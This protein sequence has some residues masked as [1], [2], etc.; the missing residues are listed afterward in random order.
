M[1][2]LGKDWI[3]I[4]SHFHGWMYYEN[5]CLW[6]YD[7]SRCLFEEWMEFTRFYN[8][9]YRVSFFIIHLF[10]LLSTCFCIIHLF[11][12]LSH[13]CNIWRFFPFS[14]IS[15]ALSTLTRDSFDVKALRAFRVLRP[16][17]L[18]SGVPSKFLPNFCILPPHSNYKFTSS[19]FQ[20]YK[21][22]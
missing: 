18:V 4:S 13:M 5:Y 3:Y 7:A 6:V 11:F 17:R 22:F 21:L 14:M 10:F 19:I 1:Y 2:F 12:F 15:T 8:C 16:L 20:V 9:S